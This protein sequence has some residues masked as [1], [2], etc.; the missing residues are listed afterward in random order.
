MNIIDSSGWLE[1]FADGPHA[2]FFAKPILKKSK[3]IIMPAIII[4]EIFKKILIEKDEDIALQTIGQIKKYKIISLDDDMAL[5]AAKLSFD[6]KLPMADSIIY[7][8]AKKHKAV[9]W[10]MDEHFKKLPGVKY[11][12]SKIR[13]S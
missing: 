8:V 1:Y 2:N 3:Q 9:I 5:S 11:I 6:L 10:T 4:Y 7:A 12:S 13:S